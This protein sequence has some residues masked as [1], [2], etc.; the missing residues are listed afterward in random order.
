MARI[1]IFGGTFNPIHR[2]HTALA[3][4]IVRHGLVDEVWLM[5]SPQNPLKG[6]DAASYDD[7][8]RMAELAT[9]NIKGVVPSNFERQLPLPSYTITTLRHLQT[10]YPQHQFS[11]I[12][13]GDNWERFARWYKSDE[14]RRDFDILIY[15]RPGTSP[16]VPESSG[17][18]HRQLLLHC[19]LH[20]ISSTE[21]RTRLA[22]GESVKGLLN[23]RVAQY[24]HRK[25]LYT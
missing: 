22:Q 7:R 25:G 14:I 23:Y 8:F 21:I 9:Y 16:V 15:P 11:L 1:G 2:G 6:N 10:T 13:G 5:V 18:P 3:K 12:I 17:T 4:S 20:D 24:I 19:T